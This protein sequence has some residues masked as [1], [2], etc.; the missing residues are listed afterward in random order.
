MMD[1]ARRNTASRSSGPG[2]DTKIERGKSGVLWLMS[3][4]GSASSTVQ[5]R[6]RQPTG[7]A[8]PSTGA[9]AS[10]AVC[11]RR[12]TCGAGRSASGRSAQSLRSVA[13]RSSSVN[14]P[15]TV[16][17]A[18]NDVNDALRSRSAQR[19]V[20]YA[21]AQWPPWRRSKSSTTPAASPG[22]QK[23]SSALRG[24]SDEVSGLRRRSRRRSTGHCCASGRSREKTA[25]R[26]RMRNR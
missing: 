25:G 20:P 21:S 1:S 15:E 22:N 11:I 23:C 2:T 17:I 9:R 7:S 3:K 19:R 16:E 18:P 24:S 4:P 5:L 12:S 8:R 6:T 26:S 13:G 10:I 14:V